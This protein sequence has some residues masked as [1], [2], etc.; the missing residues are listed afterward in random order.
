MF[1]KVSNINSI[2]LVCTDGTTSDV[3]ITT[4]NKNF[5]YNLNIP[6]NDYNTK[7]RNL[8]KSLTNYTSNS[9][10]QVLLN[11]TITAGAN[12][13]EVEI[14]PI[15]FTVPSNGTTDIKL[16]SAI[17]F[18]LVTITDESMTFNPTIIWTRP[19]IDITNYKTVDFKIRTSNFTGTKKLAFYYNCENLS[20]GYVRLT[21]EA[22][23]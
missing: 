10:T 12:Q 19:D 23:N 8:V 16:T 21:F 20:M 6:E 2:N 7:I 9:Q 17:K 4:L 15:N 13:P 14:S 1:Y 5:K 3:T 22:Q 18:K 11:T